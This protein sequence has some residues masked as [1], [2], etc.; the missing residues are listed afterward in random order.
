MEHSGESNLD[1]H[2]GHFGEHGRGNAMKLWLDDERL[3]PEGWDWA[4]TAIDVMVALQKNEYDVISLDHDLGEG[5]TGYEV[6]CFIEAQVHTNPKLKCPLEIRIHSDNPA[7]RKN[8]EL[9]LQSIKR[10][11]ALRAGWVENS[12]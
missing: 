6:M 2:P 9:A 5:R 10:E 3:P 7:G 8:M 1:L 11:L 4:C 12:R